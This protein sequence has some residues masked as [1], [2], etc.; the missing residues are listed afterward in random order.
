MIRPFGNYIEVPDNLLYKDKR[1][2]LVLY[3][4]STAYASIFEVRP[5]FLDSKQIQVGK[6]IMAGRRPALSQ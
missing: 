4:P 5:H 1:P 6:V 3:T 2:N